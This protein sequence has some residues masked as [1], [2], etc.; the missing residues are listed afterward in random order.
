LLQDDVSTQRFSQR[1]GLLEQLDRDLRRLDRQA[2]GVEAVDE[3]YASAATLLGTSAV[4]QAFELHTEPQELRDRYGRHTVGQ[5]A[6]LGRRLIE[7]GVPFVTVYSP[8]G[9]VDGPSW[10]T[11]QK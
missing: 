2:A 8:V 10:D 1:R 5:S 9:Q 4:Q 11:H 6:L 7:A 3:Y